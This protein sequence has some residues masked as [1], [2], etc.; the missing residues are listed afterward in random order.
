[1]F[2]EPYAVTPSG[3]VWLL[4]G[5][6]G[7]GDV[8][9]SATGKC[10]EFPPLL[11]GETQ[12]A[13]ST[14]AL[15]E[16]LAATKC[17]RKGPF[18]T[19]EVRLDAE[20]R[21]GWVIPYLNLPQG[22]QRVLAPREYREWGGFG[23]TLL[24]A[25]GLPSDSALSCSLVEPST[26]PPVL[27]FCPVLLPP[28]AW[29]QVQGPEMARREAHGGG[30]KAAAWGSREEAVEK[31]DREEVPEPGEVGGW[32]QAC[33]PSAEEEQVDESQRGVDTLE[34]QRIWRRKR[35]R[36]KRRRRVVGGRGDKTG[37]RHTK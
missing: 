29:G 10:L 24:H 13:A 33:E 1:M 27:L 15:W 34:L 28:P 31:R 26:G 8:S 14:L 17:G 30:A 19:G 22:R 32:R 4:T 25:A 20:T 23:L 36:S 18:Q 21:P 35:R 9:G 5:L 6:P 37:G 2:R 16:A 11:S 3:V 7:E 12:R